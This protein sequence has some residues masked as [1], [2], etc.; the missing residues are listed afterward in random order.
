M[1][2]LNFFV[3]VLTA[4]YLVDKVGRKP[5]LIIASLGCAVA[6]VGEGTYF[7]LQDQ[8]DVD[9]SNLAWLPT[10]ALCLFLIMNPLGIQSLVYVLL[11]EL[12]PTN[13]KGIA[14]SVFTLYG[15]TLA[16]LVS[17]FFAPLSNTWGRYTPFWFFAGICLLGAVFVWCCLP[18]TKGKTFAEIQELLKSKKDKEKDL[19]DVC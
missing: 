19:K 17:K 15:G 5:L 16:F 11:G 14:V 6:L 12:F 7:Y 2:Y 13:I 3:S 18:E 1:R 4:S 9:I 10:S 8:T